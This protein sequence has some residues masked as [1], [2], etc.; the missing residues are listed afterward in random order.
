MYVQYWHTSYL[1]DRLQNMHVGRVLGPSSKVVPMDAA[2][3]ERRGA[4]GG[5]EV[6]Q[7][8]WSKAYHSSPVVVVGVFSSLAP[9]VEV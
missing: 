9:A 8:K 5:W 3:R 1:R 4:E 7:V 2:R 6:L